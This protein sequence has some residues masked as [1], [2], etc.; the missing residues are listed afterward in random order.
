MAFRPC[1]LSGLK[2]CSTDRVRGAEAPLFHETTR[3]ILLRWNL[4]MPPAIQCRDLRKTYD[5]S[6]RPCAYSVYFSAV[7]FSTIVSGVGWSGLR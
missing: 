6:L 2:P 7:A 4:L 3:A 1:G 5:G